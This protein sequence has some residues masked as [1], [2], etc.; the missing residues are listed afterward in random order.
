L[1]LDKLK[2]NL[3]LNQTEYSKLDLKFDRSLYNYIY[4]TGI[5]EKLGARPL[6]RAIEREISNP[7]ARKLLKENIDCATTKI[8]MRAKNNKVIIDSECTIIDSG[9]DAPPFYMRAGN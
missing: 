7:L 2:R 6:I 8:V 5:D 4:K 3:R 9:T 1:E